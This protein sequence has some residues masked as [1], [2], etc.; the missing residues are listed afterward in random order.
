LKGTW[1]EKNYWWYNI[2]WRII[3][4]IFFSYYFSKFIN[5]VWT[6]KIIKVCQVFFVVTALSYI[7]LNPQELFD[8]I[9]SLNGILGAALVL[10]SV[11]FYFIEILRSDYIIAFYKSINFYIS[12]IVFIWYLV[13]TPIVFFNIYFSASDWDFVFLKWEMYLSMNIFMYLG[14]AI[15]LFYCKPQRGFNQ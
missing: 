9:I 1:A 14:F 12:S 11:S 8:N 4:P 2:F 10:I 15:A 5:V 13:L 6:K 7:F 3:A